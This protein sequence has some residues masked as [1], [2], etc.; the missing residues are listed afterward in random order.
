M[1]DLQRLACRD[2]SSVFQGQE[3]T[4]PA[5]APALLVAAIIAAAFGF[6]SV[7]GAYAAIALTDRA[8]QDQ[9]VVWLA[10]ERVPESGLGEAFHLLRRLFP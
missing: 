8:I 3:Q 2:G 6:G 10:P 1:Q 5:W 9:S 7:A 4:M